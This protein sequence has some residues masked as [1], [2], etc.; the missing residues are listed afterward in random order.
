VS[1]VDV[2]G[3]TVSIETTYSPVYL[4]SGRAVF[5]TSVPLGLRGG[6]P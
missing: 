6:G 5:R 1:G 2:A 4:L 3:D